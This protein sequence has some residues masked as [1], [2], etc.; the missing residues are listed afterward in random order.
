MIART[1]WALLLCGC[2][3]WLASAAAIVEPAPAGDDFSAGMR[4]YREGRFQDALAAFTR[5]ARSRGEDASAE[6]YHNQAL[7]ALRSG[8]LEA[9]ES[10][11]EHAA[12]RGGQGFVA[13]RDF[14]IGNVAFVRCGQAELLASQSEA[15]PFAFDV[16][17]AHAQAARSSWQR[18]AIQRL[19][20]PEARRNVERALLK[21]QTLKNKKAQIQKKKE[22]GPGEPPPEPERSAEQ[23]RDREDEAV[24]DGKPEPMTSLLSPEEVLHLLDKLAQKEREKRAV[25]EARRKLQETEVEKDW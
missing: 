9:A 25:R 1:Q 19:D 6:L 20:W 22:K 5:A 12:L 10:A 2:S 17:I 16:A 11:A 18:A 15:E 13:I 7:A 3:L 24:R 8:D 23:S 14:L 4:A 21:L